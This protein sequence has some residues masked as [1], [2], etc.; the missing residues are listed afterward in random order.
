MNTLQR[1][2]LPTNEFKCP[3]DLYVHIS[4]SNK[5][6]FLSTKDYYTI[7]SGEIANFDTYY[8]IFNV[9]KWKK[10]AGINDLFFTIKGDGEAIVQINWMNNFGNS[11]VVQSF[12]ISLRGNE[13]TVR[14]FEFDK[15]KLGY[16]YITIVAETDFKIYRDSRFETSDLV[17][18][19]VRLAIVI[20]HFNRA[21]HVIPTIQKLLNFIDNNKLNQC[22]SVF[23]VD[24]SRNLNC[25]ISSPN[26]LVIENPNFGG[27][28]GFARGLIEIK[29]RSFTHCLYMDDDGSCHPESIF[30]VLSIFQHSK[31]KDLA[32][33][34]T[35]LA[36]E[37][38]NII[39][40][41][42]AKYLYSGW[43]NINFGED[44]STRNG[45]LRSEKSFEKPDYGAWPFYAFA[46]SSINRFPFP[47]FVRGDDVC[48]G[49]QNKL[50]T[51]WW[52]GIATLVGNLIE[53]ESPGTLYHDERAMLVINLMQNTSLRKIMKQYRKL[54]FRELFSYKYSSALAMHMALR[55]VLHGPEFFSNNMDCSIV[56]DKL[57]PLNQEERLIDIDIEPKFAKPITSRTKLLYAFTC[58]GLLL[59]SF[60]LKNDAV[61]QDKGIAAKTIQT[62]NYKKI[63]YYCQDNNRCQILERSVRRFIRGFAIYVLDIC[64][65][66]ASGNSV[67]KK[68]QHTNVG[69]EDFWLKKINME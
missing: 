48:F 10:V 68:Y 67:R 20:T 61:Y 23:V 46:I 5:G 14:L 53:R 30:R 13:Y 57:K 60:M 37:T 8:N 12:P 24:N 11:V 21:D 36:E 15:H 62:F 4:A 40:Q 26:L 54:Y 56:R 27:A 19:N 43:K 51:I 38:P 52:H 42:G 35:L 6:N 47:F 66:L 58:K 1:I 50:T 41:S 34:G 63:F 22:I 32:L 55:D 9:S 16:L 44:I 39:L 65:L 7:A 25:N 17:E 29:R 2:A 33:V 49:L 69:S 28:G 59:P 31:I 3:I 64:L 18:T 45:I